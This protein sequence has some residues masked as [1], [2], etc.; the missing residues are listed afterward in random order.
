MM[1]WGKTSIIG[2]GYP[3]ADSKPQLAQ[4]GSQRFYMY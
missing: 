3:G 1:E 4:L 2:D